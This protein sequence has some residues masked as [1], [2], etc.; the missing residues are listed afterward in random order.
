MELYGNAV[1]LSEKVLDYLW[2]RQNITLSNI[3]NVDTPGFKSQFVT[4]EAEL[5]QRIQAANAPNQGQGTRRAIAGA[6]EG[7]RVGLV[8][9]W[10]ESTR[11][12]GNN[13]DMDQEQV[14]LVRTVY[15]YQQLTTSI[16][17][18]IARMRTAVRSF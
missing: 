12:D 10:N 7:A 11:L 4:F 2:G 1:S 13:V 17:S 16:N 6:I 15:E 14:E 18:E 8:T 5:A 9:T 3:A